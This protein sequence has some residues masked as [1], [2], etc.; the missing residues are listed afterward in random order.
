MQ[1]TDIIIIGGGAC[2][3]LAAN[4]LSRYG[5]AVTLLEAREDRKSVV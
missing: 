3:L 5:A 4:E 2:G 1:E